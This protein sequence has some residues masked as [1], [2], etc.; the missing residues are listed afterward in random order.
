MSA[1]SG[2]IGP[3][4]DK[5]YKDAVRSGAQAVNPWPLGS[6]GSEA[7][8]LGFRLGSLPRPLRWALWVWAR[9]CP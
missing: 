8:L 3:N 7:W 4:I 2:I 9:V 6:V 1:F 5:G